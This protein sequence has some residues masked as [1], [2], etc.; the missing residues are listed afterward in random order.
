MKSDTNLT[1]DDVVTFLLEE[2]VTSTHDNLVVWTQRYP[3]FADELADYFA[4]W[5]VQEEA[6]DDGISDARSEHFTNVGVSHAL[7]LL[8]TRKQEVPLV[9]APETKAMSLAQLCKRAGRTLAS[10]GQHV[11][12]DEETV[13]KL[14]L[15]RIVLDTIPRVLIDRVATALGT[16]PSEIWSVLSA[17]PRATSKGALQKSRHRPQIKTESFEEAIR[18][19]TLPPEQKA[20]W[21]RSLDEGVGPP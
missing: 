20:E 18:S 1:F 4:E 10:L 13:M 3:Q 7:N 17:P 16:L 15:C 14:D 21:L 11:R 2:D 12:L 8:H 9:R 19:S 6:D 5:A